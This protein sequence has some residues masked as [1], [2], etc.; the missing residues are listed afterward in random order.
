MKNY[1][2]QEIEN[3][4]QILD[5]YKGCAGGDAKPSIEK[6]IEIA[7]NC[8]L[9]RNKPKWISVDEGLPEKQGY[10]RDVKCNVILVHSQTEWGFNEPPSTWEKEIV[11]SALFDTEQKIWHILEE[12]IHL[13]AIINPDDLPADYDYISF[14]MYAPSI[15]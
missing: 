11:Y 6:S 5:Y 9:N 8:I 14:W 2:D 10:G 15:E 13:N 7:R 3:A 1:T 12:G 4:L